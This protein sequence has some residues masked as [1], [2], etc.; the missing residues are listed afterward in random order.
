MKRLM[1]L[2]PAVLGLAASLRA[3]PTVFTYSGRLTDGG[4]PATGTYDLRFA[5]YDST[6]QTV[7]LGTNQQPGVPVSNGLFTVGLDFG[8]NAFDGSDRWLEIRVRTNGSTG[9]FQTLS[10]RQQ[11]TSVP[12]AIFARTASNIVN[13]AAVRSLNNLRDNVT[14]APG[15]NVAIVPSGNSLIISAGNAGGSGI[16]SPNG[17]NTYFNSGNVGLGTANPASRL[18]IF[19]AQDAMRITGYQPLLTL[20]DSN[21]ANQ[22]G[23]IQSVAGGL[24]FFSE[25]YL[26]AANPLGYFRL[27]GSGRLGIGTATPT[28]PLEIASGGLRFS[29]NG[30]DI[31]FTEVADVT[32]WSAGGGSG[33]PIFRAHVGVVP[34][35]R[36]AV[37]D[38]GDVK[39]GTNANLYAPASEENLRIVRGRVNE[40]ASAPLGCCFSVAHPLSAAYDIT[41]AQPFSGQ[42]II[43]VTPLY[44]GFTANLVP[45]GDPNRQIRIVTK[46]QGTLNG[47]AFNF[48]AI[49]P[50]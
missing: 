10:P 19:G 20:R 22:R 39:L 23:V 16:W 36:F 15:A 21:S 26:N 42:P 48:I 13:G 7:T 24:N 49:G 9:A 25:N 14:L 50:R 11:I 27:D 6:N 18:D 47:S 3:Q 44:D 4:S 45:L 2:A 28:R 40:D 34:Q 46:Y 8:A 41:F 30:G 1:L 29:S 35:L 31:D 5:I 12:Y 38:N 17:T 32:A 37:M 33:L 43:T